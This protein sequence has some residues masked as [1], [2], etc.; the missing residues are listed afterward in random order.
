MEGEGGVRVVGVADA[1]VVDR[2]GVL[3]LLLPRVV[4]QPEL[5]P[6]IDTIVVTGVVVTKVA[7]RDGAE[8]FG[9]KHVQCGDS[10]EMNGIIVVV[11]SVGS[12][13][14]QWHSQIEESSV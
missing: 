5:V 11:C 1:D 9:D 4:R 6:F 3:Q 7:V 2:L 10:L 14:K 12:W 8:I 13:C